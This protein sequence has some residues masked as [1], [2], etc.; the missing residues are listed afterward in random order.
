MLFGLCVNIAVGILFG[1]II[2]IVANIIYYL[3]KLY[4]YSNTSDLPF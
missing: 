1:S 2:S 3:T 4:H